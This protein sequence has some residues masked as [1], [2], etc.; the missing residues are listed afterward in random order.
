MYT[1]LCGFV[2]KHDFMRSSVWYDTVFP[3]SH[4][5]LLLP[6]G[7][8]VDRHPAMP[9]LLRAASPIGLQSY[10]QVLRL[11]DMQVLVLSNSKSTAVLYQKQLNGKNMCQVLKLAGSLYIPPKGQEC[12]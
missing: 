9:L 5:A 8:C 11:Y 2:L 3:V 6:R 1:H 10:H 4:R 7:C 12:H